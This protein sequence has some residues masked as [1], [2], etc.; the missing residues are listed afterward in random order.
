MK[1]SP[2]QFTS[3]YIKTMATGLYG[4]YRLWPTM[5]MAV[6]LSACAVQQS[7]QPLPLDTEKVFDS[8]TSRDLN[9]PELHD[10]LQAHGYAPDDWPMQAWDVDA[11]TLAA[12]YF[13]PDLK[14]AVAEWRQQQAG[15]ITAAQ[16][17]NPVFNLPLEWHTDTSG[18]KSPWLIGIVLDLILERPGKRH[19]RI[20]QAELNTAVARLEIDQAAWDIRSRVHTAVADLMAAQQ[21]QKS[22]QRRLDIVTDILDLLRRREELGQMAAFELSSNRLELQ[23]LQLELTAQEAR[24]KTARG[25]LA[26]AI[27][28]PPAALGDISINMPTAESLPSRQ[29]VPAAD[30]RGLALQHRYDIRQS[31]AA[32]AAQEAAL[33]LEIE[34][35]YPDINLSPGFVFDQNDNIWQLGAAW[36]LPLF[37]RHEGEIAE[38]MAQR[39]VLQE[40]FL[41]LQAKIIDR[42]YQAR[43]DF[44][45]KLE[46][47][48]QA[49][50]LAE[51]AAD[52]SEGIEQQ[53]SAGYADRLQFLR[54]RQVA[55]EADEAARDNRAELLH[56]YATLE[57][58]LQYPIQ[59]EDRTH[60]VTAS[61]IEKEATPQGD[62]K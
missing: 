5:F 25:Q 42:V 15:E 30:I 46:S 22:L 56:S 27:G 23:R 14:V 54:A 60:S 62:G 16:R 43:T 44:I 19:A 26:A 24:I 32:Y 28:V 1:E 51:D 58:I 41:Q 37:H 59:G 2:G 39:S 17:I 10:F 36:I 6:L 49:V 31:L 20:E 9:A 50:I 52:Y 48:Q 13:S 4:N 61:L 47:Y 38:A 53:L 21:K 11:L 35:Q 3:K 40:R 29:Q 57:N 55:S 45:G 7:Y 12:L 34:K 18:G 8:Y 33:R